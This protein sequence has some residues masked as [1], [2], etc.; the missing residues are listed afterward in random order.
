M[1]FDKKEVLY[2][3]ELYEVQQLLQSAQTE[4]E[5]RGCFQGGGHNERAVLFTLGGALYMYPHQHFFICSQAAAAAAT[6][7]GITA[8]ALHNAQQQQLQQQCV[9][10]ARF[11]QALCAAERAG[12][13][14]IFMQVSFSHCSERERE[15][16]A[17]CDLRGEYVCVSVRCERQIFVIVVL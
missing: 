8:A 12:L 13:S 3:S 6:A 4:R 9:L 14:L 11:L 15:R 5:A 2:S 1:S 16:R 17:V 7:A 10:C